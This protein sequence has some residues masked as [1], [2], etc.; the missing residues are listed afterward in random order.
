[1]AVAIKQ[2]ETHAILKGEQRL[3]SDPA[4]HV[5]LSASAGTGKTYVLSARVLRLLLRGVAPDAILCLTFTKAGAAEMAERVHERLAHWVRLKDTELATELK[6]LDEDFGPEAV[7]V[8][9]TL[10][11]KV[12]EARGG[13]LRI[14]TIHAFCQ[15]LLGG[16]PMEAGIAPG[17]R[18][19]EGREEAVLQQGVLADLVVD[20]E[21]G[22]DLRLLADLQALSMRLGEGE[23]IRYLTRAASAVDALNEIG[24]RIESVVRQE[25][26]VPLDFSIGDIEIGCADEAFDRATLMQLV[27]VLNDWGTTRALERIDIISNWLLGTAAQRAAELPKLARAWR[28]ADG[29]LFASKGYV[30]NDPRYLPLVERID[31]WAGNLIDQMARGELAA[32]TTSAL[33][34]ALAYAR[35]YAE[36]KRT[37]GLVDFND[38]ISLT[39]K[40]LAEPG[41]GEWIRFKLDQTT[42]HILVDESQDT[43]QAQW[44][45]VDA[46][47]D[48]FWAGAGAKPDVSRTLFAVG[49]YKQ[50]IYGF[51]GT[52]PR[53]Y[54][55]A[56]LAF[57]LKAV[58]AE[59][60]FRRLSL[61][62]SFRSTPPVLDV[63]DAVI[64]ELGH[65]AM[66]LIEPAPR[67]ESSKSTLPG[68][69]LLFP[70][71]TAETGEDE[72]G[73]EDWLSEAPRLLADRLARQIK[74]WL[75]EPLWLATDKGRAL[76][77]GDIM[78][79]VR[80]RGE[81]AALL[82]ARLHQQGI[83][84]A[85]VDR[86]RLQAPIAVQDLL[87]TMRFAAQP[88]DDLNLAG[89]LVSPLLGWSQGN[90]F[91]IAHD[92]SGTLWDAMPDGEARAALLGMLSAADNITPYAF[93][94]NVLSG[95]MEG[96]RKLLARLGE[97]ARDP[98][99]ELLNAALLF[100]REGTA[101]LQVFLDWFDRGE[102]EVVRDADAAGDAVRVMTVH[103]AKGLQAPFV[104]LADACAD[105]D[106]ARETGF[107]WSIED[108]VND[109]PS[110]KPRK[111]EQAL[112][113]S[114]QTA[115]ED[116]EAKARREHWR[117]LYVAMTRAEEM[118]V[119]AGAL[120]PR[121]QG[122]VPAESWH[123]TI[124][125]AMV[126][127]GAD[128]VDD[129]NW[130]GMLR[131]GASAALS[132]SK[133]GSH[134]DR[135]STTSSALRTV[136]RPAWLHQPA[137][138]EARPP[139]PLAPSS[140][141]EDDTV[142]P[143]PS[144]AMAAAAERG[145]LLHA[146]FERLPS[147]APE[148]RRAA[149]EAWLKSEGAEPLLVDV[150]LDVIND[151]N[152]ANV[153]APDALAEAPIAGVVEGVVIAGTVD[154]LHVTDSI[155]EIIDFKTGR[156]VPED[157][158]SISVA[159][160]RQ[161]AAYLAV[162]EGIFPDRE[163]RAALLYSEGPKLHHLPPGLLARHKPSFVAPQD[164]LVTAS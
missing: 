79:L 29:D 91:D 73:D 51:Q 32:A 122:V 124:E 22:G 148:L 85:G 140:I 26:N 110:L 76:K 10:F 74:A 147:L 71:V 136:D 155:V 149:G 89:L 129:A 9:R 54:E 61:S 102:T 1:M 105:P 80:K 96:R 161:M 47:A 49:D 158:Q 18:P 30:P 101:S 59:R 2:V 16:F 21:R 153:F 15:T 123:A 151:P 152:F 55:R 154:R 78:I 27:A 104:I 25:M 138:Q 97:E 33:R 60:E 43:N 56:G 157:P 17:F 28:K 118:L 114:L 75:N 62:Q 107:K 127:M 131:Y 143:P 42:D 8:A 126:G 95:T 130:G 139:R 68:Q 159:H 163:V 19:L 13:G 11:A 90:L 99:D 37:R 88:R 112:V 53:H 103:G 5:W 63:V 113:A 150:A 39:R 7:A 4:E 45:I 121:A 137:P 40:L 86:L 134:V 70:P 81:L 41:M 111:A 120:G 108:V 128:R 94:E 100:E 84:V 109:L 132:L 23:V 58:R 48:E 160:L 36:A 65:E 92:R 98:V 93:L 64:C 52:D 69:V 125:R 38:Q 106:N 24:A 135:A 72:A 67:H 31:E 117:L 50:A 35:A 142:N 144:A 115:V 57:E 46:L 34:A 3:A 6:A 77:P 145:R 14:M 116:A 164:K 87:S 119:V 12:L 156:R 141:G 146:L 133:G 82:V 44:D 66:G 162:L 20:A 83:P